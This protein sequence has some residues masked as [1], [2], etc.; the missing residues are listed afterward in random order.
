MIGSLITQGNT[1]EV[2]GSINVCGLN[3]TRTLR[4][5]GAATVEGRERAGDMAGA[6]QN[7]AERERG[8]THSFVEFF[9]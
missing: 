8:Q 7:R 1:S 3:D 4:D 5:Q 2:Q 6:E 9:I